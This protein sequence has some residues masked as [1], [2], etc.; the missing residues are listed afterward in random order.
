MKHRLMVL[1]AAAMLV[2]GV[3]VANAAENETFGSQPMSPELSRCGPDQN[4]CVDQM[5]QD[6]QMS[7]SDAEVGLR[8]G[9]DEPVIEA[10]AED[11]EETDADDASADGQPEQLI[12]ILQ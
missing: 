1:A 5:T 9:Q 8:L 7:P 3:G 6:N 2:F 11:V 10:E 12:I 4:L